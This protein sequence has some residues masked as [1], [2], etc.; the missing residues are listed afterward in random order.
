MYVSYN[1]LRPG[2]RSGNRKR[3]LCEVINRRELRKSDGDYVLKLRVIDRE[4]DKY[5]EVITLED[6]TVALSS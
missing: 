5:Q 1:H 6:G 3:P 4:D 2:F